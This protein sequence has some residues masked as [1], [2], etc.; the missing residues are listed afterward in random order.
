MFKK[1]KNFFKWI[2]DHIEFHGLQEKFHQAV[3]GCLVVK[4][5]K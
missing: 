1:I 2:A 3:S 5:V 4:K